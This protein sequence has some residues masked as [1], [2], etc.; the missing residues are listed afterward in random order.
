M[1]FLKILL[2]TVVFLALAFAGFAIK[3]FLRKDGE[4]KK[5]CSSVHPE[6]G[7]RLGCVCGDGSGGENCKNNEEETI[8]RIQM[9]ALETK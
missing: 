1:I 3:M 8:A 2:V 7:E 6:T 5:Q 9:Q 4:F